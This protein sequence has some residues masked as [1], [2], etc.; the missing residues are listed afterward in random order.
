MG[1]LCLQPQLKHSSLQTHK[2]GRALLFKCVCTHFVPQELHYAQAASVLFRITNSSELCLPGFAGRRG[3]DA[4]VSEGMKQ[5][6]LHGSVW[7]QVGWNWL[8]GRGQRLLNT[9]LVHDGFLQLITSH[10]FS[11][12]KKNPCPG[13]T[14]NSSF[15]LTYTATTLLWV[16]PA[17]NCCFSPSISPQ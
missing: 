8:A 15:Q 10:T 5:R 3:P 9:L 17:W 2:D 13:K 1:D 11:T 16:P 4:A 14:A 12:V 7:K 6:H